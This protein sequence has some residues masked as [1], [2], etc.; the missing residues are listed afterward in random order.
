MQVICVCWPLNQLVL[1]GRDPCFILAQRMSQS[2]AETIEQP[3]SNL[4]EQSKQ[5]FSP[6]EGLK[7]CQ[8]FRAHEPGAIGVPVDRSA[9]RT[10]TVFPGRMRVD[11][12][13]IASHI[14]H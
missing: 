2:K 4:C 11:S 12:H 14:S 3:L 10:T 8:H 1:N 9:I 5:L 6:F 13:T 7:G